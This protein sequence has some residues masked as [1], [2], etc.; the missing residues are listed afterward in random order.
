[1]WGLDWIFGQENEVGGKIEI[2]M[3]SFKLG[4]QYYRFF[5]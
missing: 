3:Y 4:F 5:V 2:Q 1:M